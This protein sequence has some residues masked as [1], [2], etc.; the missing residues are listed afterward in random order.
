M[1]RRWFRPGFMV[2]I[3]LAL[4][5]L[6]ALACGTTDDPTPQPTPTPVDIGAIV[7]QALSGQAAGVTSADVAKAV[8]DALAGNPGVTAAQVSSEVAK[9][10][11]AALANQPGLTAGQVAS[12]IAKAL[13]TQPGVTA[14]Q[15]AS[16]I[17]KALASQPGVTAQ[18][19]SKAIE[20][21]LMAQPG[22]TDEEIAKAIKTAL[23]SQPQVT[24]DSIAKA[25]EKALAAALPTAM[26]APEAVPPDSFM[27]VGKRGG[28]IP[29]QMPNTP[30]RWYIWECP[31]TSSCMSQISPMYNGLI[32]LNME[33]RALLDVR[34]DLARS[35]DVSDDGKT[36]TFHLYDAQWWDGKPVTAEDVAFSFDMMV[37]TSNP[38]PKS[39]QLRFAYDAGGAKVI[40]EKTV[41][42]TLPKANP[43]FIP[44]LSNQQMK[45]LPKHWVSQK[46][47]AE[48]KLRENQMGSGPFVA[49]KYVKDVSITYKRNDN[50]FK[51]PRPYYDGMEWFL[52]KDRNAIIAAFKTENFLSCSSSVCGLSTAQYLDLGKDEPKISSFLTPGG[53]N[54]FVIFNTK[55]PPL[56]DPRVRKAISLALNR[57]DYLAISGGGSMGAPFLTDSWFYLS[58]EE[59]SQLPGYRVDANGEKLQEDLDAAKALLAEAGF[60]NGFETTIDSASIP[61]FQVIAQVVSDQLKR[62]LNID[63]KIK[64]KD[65]TAAQA[66]WDRQDFDMIAFGTSFLVVDP[67]FMNGSLHLPG[68][69][70][71][72]SDWTDQKVIDLAAKITNG[73]DQPTRRKFT[74][75]LGAYLEEVVPHINLGWAVGAKIV[76]NRIKNYHPPMTSSASVWHDHVWL[77]DNYTVVGERF[78]EDE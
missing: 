40:D 42:I 12:E 77:E 22:V 27:R 69:E 56:D 55:K 29:M 74:L 6:V 73:A 21:A 33:T 75:E 43:T 78:P 45:I 37:D 51:A 49:T 1:A 13:A 31:S 48:L 23:A 71:N 59:Q 4:V 57:Q 5:L 35:W 14:D 28:V 47:A 15:V 17:A 25:V 41:E 36:F 67:D 68:G 58:S 63:A 30:S 10:V 46:T 72:W 54:R 8:Q 60:P 44:L 64:P 34:G 38:F 2:V 20:T 62:Y 52:L 11:Q 50:Y 53:S 24:D 26:P 70:R 9:A 66:D 16:E 3:P 18:D 76:S 19:M 39:G 65:Y 32:E 61:T 7:A